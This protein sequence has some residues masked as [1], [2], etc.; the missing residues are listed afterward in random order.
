MIRVL[1]VCHGNL[2]YKM[3]LKV[4]LRRWKNSIQLKFSKFEIHT[5]IKDGISYDS[6]ERSK[7]S[8]DKNMER[9]YN[10]RQN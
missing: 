1:F 3:L 9:W 10:C 4:R 7:I 6:S 2:I 8:R 5:I